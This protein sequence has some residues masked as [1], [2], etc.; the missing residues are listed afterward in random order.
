MNK[1]LVTGSAIFIGSTLS[2]F[3]LFDKGDK[4]IGIDNITII[5]ILK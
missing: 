3:E 4:V 1:V 2:K 5:T